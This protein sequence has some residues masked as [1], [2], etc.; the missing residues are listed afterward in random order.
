MTLQFWFMFPAAMLIATIAMA[1]GVEGAT[2]F[3]PL[4]IL[5]LGLPP[6]VAVG[7]GLITEVFGFASG[8]FSY[9]RKKL[10]DYKLGLF[11]LMITVPLAVGGTFLATIV[12]SFVLKLLLGAGLIAIALS[13]LN[14]P[15]KHKIKALN[16]EIKKLYPKETAKTTLVTAEGEEI[17]YTVCNKAQGGLFGGIGALLIGMIST[18]Q[19]ELNGYFF[20]KRCKVPSKVAVAT[21]VFIVAVTAL[22]ASVGHAVRF[23]RSGEETLRLVL[24]IVIF[25]I[26]GVVI[27]G[28]IGSFIAAKIPQ[29]LLEKVLAF[30]FLG[31]AALMIG[32]TLYRLLGASV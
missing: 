12:P 30:L 27:G 24:S 31:V 2:F 14:S 13:F 21:S 5:A 28:Q 10:I 7:V 1:S 17:H 8:V 3:T 18:G 19:G 23:A 29:K 15:D 20:L 26:P 22:S 11:M 4:F 32:E 9:A 25:T 6:E 16:E